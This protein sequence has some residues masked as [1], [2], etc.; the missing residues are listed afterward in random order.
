MSYNSKKKR[1]V[2][3]KKLT[4]VNLINKTRKKQIKIVKRRKLTKVRLNNKTKKK[5]VRKRPRSKKKLIG[6]ANTAVGTPPPPAAAAV[7]A[8]DGYD[9]DSDDSENW[10]VGDED[11]DEFED[12]QEL[13]GNGYLNI[14]PL[15]EAAPE[16]V[17]APA[18]GAPEVAN[19]VKECTNV[20]IN[21]KKDE[22]IEKLLGKIKQ[23]VK[24]EEFFYEKKKTKI[25]EIFRDL[26]FSPKTNIGCGLIQKKFYTRYITAVL[27]YGRDLLKAIIRI[28]YK[29]KKNTGGK[30]GA[31][32]KYKLPILE[33]K[34]DVN[35]DCDEGTL[36]LTK[37]TVLIDRDKRALCYS[38]EFGF[39]SEKNKFKLTVKGKKKKKIKKETIDKETIEIE[40]YHDDIIEEPKFESENENDELTFK[41]KANRFVGRKNKETFV[42]KNTNPG[43]NHV[44]L[45][46]HLLDSL[47]HLGQIIEGT[48]SIKTFLEASENDI[49]YIKKGI[50]PKDPS[51]FLIEFLKNTRIQDLKFPPEE[52]IKDYTGDGKNYFNCADSS[53]VVS[54]LG[55][56]ATKVVQTAT[57]VGEVAEEGILGVAEEHHQHGRD[58]RGTSDGAVV[59]PYAVVIPRQSGQP[60]Y[61]APLPPPWKTGY[62]KNP[63]V[64]EAKNLFI[65]EHFDGKRE[66]FSIPNINTLITTKYKNDKTKLEK[67]IKTMEGNKESV[68]AM[69]D[70]LDFLKESDLETKLHTIVNNVFFITFNNNGLYKDKRGNLDIL[71]DLLKYLSNL[72]PNYTVLFE[73]INSNMPKLKMF[74]DKPTGEEQ[75][76]FKDG[77]GNF[78]D[79]FTT[80]LVNPFVNQDV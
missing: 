30:R 47:Y 76:T 63:V 55:N 64:Q 21:F 49:E 24:V 36:Q 68:D 78:N 32:Q 14:G 42:F 39:D 50:F 12:P 71:N 69:T 1:K 2:K 34:R 19:C 73:M 56:L 46:K 7:E 26:Q 13:G 80:Q 25:E 33:I 61:A 67:S 8:A 48:L 20:N 4:K 41:L 72:T 9:S 57:E 37:K 70:Q 77:F 10:P 45:F 5:L 40:I 60:E 17:P 15:P 11:E 3:R 6:G 43:S 75:K 16:G 74:Q 59:S 79:D 23:I 38:F 52:Y 53:G 58:L 51:I 22:T 54:Q 18:E 44:K 62:T 28:V 31:K 29:I 66:K 65:I 27:I 35:N